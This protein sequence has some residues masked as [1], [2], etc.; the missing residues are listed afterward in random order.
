LPYCP[1]PAVKIFLITINPQKR[2]RDGAGIGRFITSMSFGENRWKLRSF[3]GLRED[4][5]KKM[6]LVDTYQ[7][8]FQWL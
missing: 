8:R 2:G 3:A 1:L 5:C 7:E 6:S 4:L